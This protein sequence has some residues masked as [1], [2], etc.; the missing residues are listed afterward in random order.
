MTPEQL[1]VL[2]DQAHQ[3][4]GFSEPISILAGLVFIGI[5]WWLGSDWF[6]RMR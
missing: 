1:S 4:E 6:Q 2:R 5:V 3:A